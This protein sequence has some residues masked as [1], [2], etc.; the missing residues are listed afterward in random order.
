MMTLDQFILRLT[1]LRGLMGG[2]IPVAVNKYRHDEFEIAM[3]EIQ[4]VVPGTYE[5]DVGT[6][7]WRSAT[8]QVNTSRI[9][10]VT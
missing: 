10:C 1:E 3:V 8:G 2:D 5:N 7:C 6:T 4:N 9:I